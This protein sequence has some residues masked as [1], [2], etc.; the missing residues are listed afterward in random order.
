M[1]LLVLFLV[2]VLNFGTYY[3][4][5]AP[6]SLNVQLEDLL[7]MDKEDWEFILNLLFVFYS[8]PNTI[9]PFFGG[10]LTDKFGCRH[11][12]LACS[13]LI[14]T[15]QIVFNLGLVSG[16][17]Y[18]TFVGRLIF[19]IG[20]ESLSVAQA[21]LTATWFDGQSL[22]IATSMNAFFA[23]CGSITN[24]IVSP[25]LD[26]YF[27][28]RI[29]VM[30][31]TVACIFS[32]TASILLY[33]LTEELSPHQQ[34]S[35][36]TPL[37]TDNLED[38]M[39]MA[40]EE[41][42]HIMADLSHLPK[43]FWVSCVTFVMFIGPYYCFN[44]TALEFLMDKWYT[45]DTVTAGF[46]MSIPMIASTTLLTVCGAILSADVIGFSVELGS[47]I[48]FTLVHLVLGYTTL[49]PTIPFILMGL[50]GAINFTLMY[51]F[52]NHCV[53]HQKRQFQKE[54]PD[55]NVKM[56]GLA[57]G[58]IVCLQNL[59]N[60]LI[61]LCVAWILTVGHGSHQWEYVELFYAGVTGIG[62][63]AS[64]W[65]LMHEMQKKK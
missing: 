55:V 33:N 39:E 60:A 5:D 54:A 10:K 49:S 17:L 13:F 50:V 27:G 9:L 14:T 22:L 3:A 63:V 29:A 43:S 8:L 35:E 42:E 52:V 51:P 11:V 40:I 34:V 44:I 61:P 36:T 65:L 58:I 6:A 16:N 62:A 4:Y 47:M 12:L 7:G 46:A 37:L 20:G 64:G 31:A 26:H 48:L 56:L 38:A 53:K 32:C 25:L 18:L 1:N 45:G 28:V 57:Y 19:G 21:V 15:G 41:V 2:S 30:G 24:A 59:A 23:K